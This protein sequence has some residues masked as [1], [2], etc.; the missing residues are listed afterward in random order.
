MQF[1]VKKVNLTKSLSVLNKAVNPRVSLPMLSN[2]LIRTEKGRLKLTASDLQL[3]ISAWI[4]AK[5]DST[6]EITVPAKLLTEF[7]S[8]ITE[9][10]IDAELSG[11]TLKLSTPKVKATFAGMPATEF[12]SIEAAKGTQS[13]TYN[14]IEFLSGL[15]KVAF[16]V[17]SDESRPVLTGI[18]FKLLGNTLTVAGTDGFRMAEHKFKTESTYEEELK[19][20]IPARSFLEVVKSFSAVSDVLTFDINLERNVI[21]VT[22]EDLEAQIRLL[23]GEYPDYEAVLPDEFATEIKLMSVE[24]ASAIKLASVFSRENGNMIKVIAENGAAQVISQPTEQGSNSSNL[25][26]EI[27]GDDVQIAF[28]ARYLL[29]FVNAVT[30]VELAFKTVEALKPGMFKII[31]NEDYFY[32]V[33]PMRASW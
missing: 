13:F 11:S 25:V 1:T 19:C 22:T 17:A 23:E 20:I 16:A 10:N 12:P 18:Y 9:E 21:L 14:S 3:T 7:A 15:S 8:Q 30:D 32:L 31:G 2:I 5:I 29:D 6:G 28:N 27:E 24:L 4:G 33:M 26:A